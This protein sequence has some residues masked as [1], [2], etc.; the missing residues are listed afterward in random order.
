M[1]QAATIFA[2]TK[3]K[4]AKDN[5][6]AFVHHCRNRLGTFGAVDW[7]APSW[8][9]SDTIQ[10][11]ARRTKVHLNWTD[12]DTTR[13]TSRKSTREA[14]AGAMPAPFADFAKSFIRYRYAHRPTTEIDGVPMF[15]LRALERS[16]K[17]PTGTHDI[18]RIDARVLN[19]AARLAAA[20]W[21]KTADRVGRYLEEIAD[22]LQ[23]LRLVTGTL[24]WKSTLR[25]SQEHGMYRTGPEADARRARSLPSQTALFAL[26][27][28]FHEAVEARDVLT[29]STAALLACAPDRISE[30][31][32]IAE[33]DEVHTSLDGK[34]SY[35]FRWFPAKGGT[36]RVKEIPKVMEQIAKEA[37]ARLLRVTAPG[38]EMAKWYARNPNRLYL[39]PDLEHLRTQE[40]LGSD[41]IAVLLGVATYPDVLREKQ[42]SYERVM[43]AGRVHVRV[44]FAEFEAWVLRQLPPGF[45]ELDRR[46]GLRYDN[47]LYVVPVGFFKRNPNRVMFQQVMW[48]QI[49]RNLGNGK[50][51]DV[52]LFNRLQLNDDDG[53][54]VRMRT[55]QLRHW[56]NTLSRKGGLSELE[57]ALWSGRKDVRSNAAYD[58]LTDDEM[59]SIAREVARPRDQSLVEFVVRDPIGRDEFDVLKIKTG[60]VTELGVC[61]HDYAMAPCHKHGDCGN[62]EEQWCVKGDDDS[63]ARIRHALAIAE[64]LHKKS[65]EALGDN[66]NGA[67]R[68]E[69]HH[70]RSLKRLRNLVA[71]LDDP[72]VPVGSIIR[73][74]KGDQ[75]TALGIALEEHRQ[76]SGQ[77]RDAGVQAIRIYHSEKRSAENRGEA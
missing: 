35:G 56:L 3:G 6:A 75:Y 54:P 49:H 45:P 25:R 10:R 9:I 15:A 7:E 77:E 13:T 29:S 65:I 73:L 68:W 71:I 34:P 47:A 51:G 40:H 64:A 41:E 74:A 12:I 16:L 67:A 17:N 4:S 60:H 70:Y 57:I 5:L 1:T 21:P 43:H 11:Q 26:A 44:R 58:D 37:Y 50:A 63:N 22:L 66:W 14:T 48:D 55:H 27:K 30:V 2:P 28:A 38:R 52:T 69:A 36:P 19:E 20:R 24:R 59:V 61:V 31:L 42:I 53:K 18:S 46:R 62:C 72:K 8:D 23:E 76:L 33:D 39:P 32:S